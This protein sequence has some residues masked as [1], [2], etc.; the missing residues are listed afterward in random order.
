MTLKHETI[1]K[2]LCSG[3]LC[4][5]ETAERTV[6]IKESSVKLRRV[7]GIAL[8]NANMRTSMAEH[9][10][11]TLYRLL[12]PWA[13]PT[14]LKRIDNLTTK[15]GRCPFGSSFVIHAARSSAHSARWRLALAS[16]SSAIS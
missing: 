2:P 16:I 10:D 15:K 8:G 4:T 14:N 5:R 6:G 13:D 12:V 9:Y 11:G 1:S 3:S 7:D